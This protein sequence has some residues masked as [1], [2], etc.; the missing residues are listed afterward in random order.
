[1]S[2]HFIP[3]SRSRLIDLCVENSTLDPQARMNF[4]Q[5]CKILLAYIHHKEHETLEQMKDWYSG[6]DPDEEKGRNDQKETSDK[7]VSTFIASLQ[8]ANYKEIGDREIQLALNQA[9]LVPVQTSVDFSIYQ[10]YLFFYQQSNRKEITE[11]KWFREKVLSFDNYSRMV[12]LLQTKDDLPQ[13]GNE[14]TLKAGKIYLYFYKNIPHYDLEMLFPNLKISMTLKDKLLLVIPAVGA[15][16]PML[17]KVLP[18]IALLSGAV[19][20]FAFGM[21][22]GTGFDAEN[23]DNTALF[24]LLTAVLSIALALGGFAFGQFIKYKSKRLGFLKHIADVLFFKCLDTGSGVIH[25]VID[26]TEEELCKEMILVLHVLSQSTE[27]LD[28]ETIDRQIEEWI[29]VHLGHDMD[30]DVHKALETL[31]GLTASG[32]EQNLINKNGKG[33]YSMSSLD[34]CK[35]IIDR[36]WDNVFQYN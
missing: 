14:E 6:F 25:K 10:R 15:A 5:L 2:E 22:I 4:Q 30:F 18:S 3:C 36:L 20:F 32:D 26:A 11:K 16:I 33:Q 17:L 34:E 31:S 24:A 29:R 1:M 28:E 23:Q 9:S 27:S 35:T 21:N 8:A 19:A 13:P 12:V 7:F